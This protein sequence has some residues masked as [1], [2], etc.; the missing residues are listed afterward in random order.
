MAEPPADTTGGANADSAP[1]DAHDSRVHHARTVSV[2]A[3][4]EI[5]GKVA[6]FAMFAVAARMLGIDDFGQFSW[7][8]SLALLIAGFVVWGFDTALIQLG[9]R[10]KSRV[11]ELLSNVLAIRLLLVPVA[12]AVVWVFP[13]GSNENDLV[14]EVLLVAVLADSANQG[15]RAAAGVIDR[16]Q[17]VAVN[18]VIQRLATAILAIGVLLAGGGLAGMSWAYLAGTLVG[19]VLMFWTGRRIGLKP[20][21]RLAS[22][23]GM[24]Q[25]VHASHALGITAT[26]NMM[27]FRVDTLLLGWLVGNEAVGAYSAAFKLFETALFVVW[28]LDRVAFPKM[29]AS[30]GDEPIRRMLNA[31]LSVM[32][33]IF[34][35]Y[36]VVM[37]IRG[38]DILTLIFGE[39]YGEVSA[40][41]LQ[42]LSLS[43]I[44]YGLQY[45][46]ASGLLARNRNVLVTVSAIVALAANIAVNLIL[47]PMWG[48]AGAAAAT[49]VAMAAQSV[50]L[51]IVLF[52]MV[53]SPRI[54]RS[55]L[56]AVLAGVVMVPILL[57]P[58]N[59]IIGAALACAAYG[60]V[61]LVAAGWLD[62]TAKRTLMAMI[63]R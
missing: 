61:W 53:G 43:L 22:V 27:A 37:A 44:P 29:A 16:Q 38:E 48:P 57:T 8:F 63:G 35:P 49:L 51:W 7:S 52:R 21:V 59:V 2:L 13:S 32:F 56:V 46:L 34:V 19:V 9:S 28:S 17:A 39:P 41:A 30:E 47:I 20:S 42:V 18:L 6:S 58:L 45:L 14:S 55:S 62:P 36:I 54:V 60:A 25:I 1:D 15:I 4:A 3:V 11:N 33:A 40:V 50:V 5:A 10:A 12:M 31:A 23:A 26:I 24:K